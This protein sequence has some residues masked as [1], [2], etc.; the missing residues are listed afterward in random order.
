MLAHRAGKSSGGGPNRS[1][2]LRGTPATAEAAGPVREQAPDCYIFKRGR[3]IQLDFARQD[4]DANLMG[5]ASPYTS[6]A[7]TDPSADGEDSNLNV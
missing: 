7:L 2:P 1:W 6:E 5:G 3:S 4:R